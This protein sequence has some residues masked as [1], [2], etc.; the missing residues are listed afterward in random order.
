M[1]FANDE[2]L[3]EESVRVKRLRSGSN[4]RAQA[5]SITNIEILDRW[6]DLRNESSNFKVMQP[7]TFIAEKRVLNDSYFNIV[8]PQPEDGENEDQAER[9]PNAKI[10]SEKQFEV[11]QMLKTRRSMAAQRVFKPHQRGRAKSK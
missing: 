9:T 4:N 5:N 2:S 11:T 6:G 3:N 10:G 8:C 7:Q 1:T